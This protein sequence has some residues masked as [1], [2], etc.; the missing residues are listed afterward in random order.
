MSWDNPNA[1][2]ILPAGILFVVCCLAIP[3]WAGYRPHFME[4][5]VGPFHLGGIVA[6]AQFFMAWIAAAGMLYYALHSGLSYL[7]SLAVALANY[8]LF[9]GPEIYRNARTRQQVSE[10]RRKFEEAKASG[11]ETL[12][13]CATC[14]RTEITN[15]ELD[16]RVARDGQEYCTEHLPKLPPATA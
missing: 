8:L 13:K 15:P 11:D 2:F 4:T 1:R 12:H 6:L 9:F 3:A 16:F 7:V 5:R 10:R 14:H